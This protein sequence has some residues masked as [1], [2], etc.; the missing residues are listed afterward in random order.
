MEGFFIDVFKYDVLVKNQI[1]NLYRS[2]NIQLT[3]FLL[4]IKPILGITG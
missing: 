4:V 2:L 3:I 1:N